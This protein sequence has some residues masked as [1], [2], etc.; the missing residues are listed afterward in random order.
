MTKE[1]VNKSDNG[2]SVFSR[3]AELLG[4]DPLEEI[5]ALNL[6]DFLTEHLISED[7]AQK[8]KKHDT[9]DK[10]ESLKKQLRELISIY[11]I[12]NTLSVLGFTNKEDYI[13]Y[14]SIAKTIVQMID[15]KACHIFL[16]N[17]YAM[18]LEDDVTGLVLVGSSINPDEEI[19]PDDPSIIRIPM[20]YGTENAGLIMIEPFEGKKISDEFLKLINVTSRLFAI[21]MMLLKLTDETSKVMAEPD[22]SSSELQHYRAELTAV[23]GDLGA[24][25]QNFV[26]M[27]AKAVDAKSE[28]HNNHSQHVADLAKE[29]CEY[30]G[31]NEKTKDLIYYAGLLQNIGKI[32]IPEELFNKKEKLSKEDWETL[33]NHPNIGVSLLMSINFLSEVIPYI[34]YHKERWDGKGE[35]EGLKGQSIP[36][37]SR[38]I[39]LADAYSALREERPY[40]QALSKEEALKIIKQEAAIKWDPDLVNVLESL[41]AK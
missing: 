35:P 39:A 20:H 33:Q 22:V 41:L 11:S 34:H 32:T 14:N 3:S 25:Q 38:I 17:E 1:N 31:L 18:G 27:L 4:D 36:F 16:A 13:I 28:Y 7:L 19:N 37:G 2:V 29:M 9:Q 24:E 26:E 23:I 10:A 30:L 5:F 21:S 40:R 15:A 8:I 12:N 6:G